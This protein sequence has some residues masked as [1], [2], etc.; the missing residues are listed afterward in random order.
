MGLSVRRQYQLEVDPLDLELQTCFFLLSASVLGSALDFSIGSEDMRIGVFCK[1]ST[2]DCTKYSC[3]ETYKY[4]S[5][6]GVRALRLNLSRPPRIEAPGHHQLHA[7]KGRIRS[8]FG[9]RHLF[10]WHFLAFL[11][12]LKKLSLARFPGRYELR[13]V[14]RQTLT[15]CICFNSRVACFLIFFRGPG[16]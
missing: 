9:R 15:I 1:A 6:S 7:R 3:I 5:E 16:L 2:S 12:L 11:L 10:V 8:V 14:S 4:L 13:R